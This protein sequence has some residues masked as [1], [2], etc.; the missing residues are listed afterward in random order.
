M[1]RKIL[2]ILVVAGL[3]LGLTVI[4]AQAG[5]AGS[6]NVALIGGAQFDHTLGGQLITSGFPG[7]STFTFTNMAVSQV[8]LANLLPYDTA[9][10]NMASKITS[11]G[12]ACNSGNLTAQAKADLNQ[13]VSNGGKLIIFDS[14]C[15]TGVD[16]QWLV[17]PFT[18]NNPG[19]MGAS[20]TLNIVEENCLSTSVPGSTHYIDAVSLGS[21]TDAVGDMNVMV[22]LDPSWCLDMSGTNVNNVTGPTHTYARYGSG[23]I[24]YNGLDQDYQGFEPQPPDPYGLTRI[25]EQELNVP[26]DPTPLTCLPCGVSVTGLSL[27][28]ISA[29]N[30]VNANHTL[31]AK[32]TDPSGKGVPGIQVSFAITAGP[33]IGLTYGPVNTDANGQATW[34]YTSASSGT[35][36]IVATATRPDG[37]QLTSS[38][39]AKTWISPNLPPDCSEAYADPACLW[40]P[41]HKFVDVAIMGVTDPDG[42][43]VTITITAITSDE[44]TATDKGSGGAKHSPDADGIGTD[45]ASVRAERSGTADGRVYVISFTASDDSGGECEGSVMVKVPHDQ[46]DKT[47]PAVDSG[48]IYYATQMN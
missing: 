46:S 34:T 32:V 39:A 37:T 9:V 44:A 13:F 16:Y 24:I 5:S 29:T 3:I 7:G 19:A 25:W 12:C 2:S 47:C 20:G 42:D 27:V 15:P 48:Q 6:V 45:T 43:P 14:E 18:T 30:N 41:N 40:P 22:T 33:N 8:S 36:T 4:P 21:L 38:P 26:F 1:K 11:G 23:L 10:L 17:Y 28:P 31:T 35:D